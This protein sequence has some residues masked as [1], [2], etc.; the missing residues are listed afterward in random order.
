MSGFD[1][2]ARE[3]MVGLPEPVFISLLP[4]YYDSTRNVGVPQRVASWSAV[5]STLHGWRNRGFLRRQ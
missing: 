1:R 5:A 2:P 4:L 3:V